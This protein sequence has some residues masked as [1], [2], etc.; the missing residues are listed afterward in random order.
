MN[1]ISV[2][3]PLRGRDIHGSASLLCCAHLRVSACYP[4]P[5]EELVITSLG[6]IQTGVHAISPVCRT[7]NKGTKFKRGF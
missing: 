1:F 6:T 2:L 7:E 3:L 5:E 4:K